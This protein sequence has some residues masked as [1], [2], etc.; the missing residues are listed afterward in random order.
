MKPGNSTGKLSSSV[1]RMLNRRAVRWII[2][3]AVIAMAGGLFLY[4][5][6]VPPVLAQSAIQSLS[7]V[8]APVKGQKVLVFSPHPD[9][10]TIGAG[11]YIAQSREDGADVRIILVTDGNYHHNK[12]IRYSEFKKATGILGVPESNLV[13]LNFPDGRLRKL[14]KTLLYEALKKQIEMYRPD[15]VVYPCPQDANPDHA[16]IGKEVEEILPA[17]PWK[18][19]AYGYLVHYEL[20][21]PQPRKYAPGLY[22]LPPKRL[23]S[24]DDWERF[25]LSQNVENLKI[26][27]ILT[28]KS[29]LKNWWL[30]GLLLSSARKNE[31]LTVPTGRYHTY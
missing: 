19:T 25:P 20:L 12:S 21:Y 1:K 2:I 8:I 6:E 11:G 9:D 30:H 31:L 29:Q 27:A 5:E 24:V 18:I 16:T 15:I 23:L 28:Y 10:E 13:F 14:D 26:S 4:R 7:D 22:L 3:A 17:E